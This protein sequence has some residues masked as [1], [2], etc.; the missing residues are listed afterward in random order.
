[1]TNKDRH[2]TDREALARLLEIHGADRTRWPA[3]ERLRFA[4]VITD[5]KAAGKLLAEAQALDRLLDKAPMS[6]EA[7]LDALK[8]RIMA[9]ALSGP[10]SRGAVVMP[11]RPAASKLRPVQT[12]RRPALPVKFADWPAAAVLAA[13]LV[14]GVMLGSAGTFDT[15]VQEVAQVTGLGADN[16]QV[17]LSEDIL[18]QSDEDML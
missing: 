1:M 13:S 4:S 15:A 2:A 16:S 14:L 8:E 5:D 3:R 12:W 9:A 10:V 7:G 18:G 11:F 17:A 6:S